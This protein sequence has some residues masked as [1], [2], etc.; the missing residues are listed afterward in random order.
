MF[1]KSFTDKMLQK[2]NSNSQGITFRGGS[3]LQVTNDKFEF[4]T[5]TNFYTEQTTE[6]IP[7]MMDYVSSPKNIPN[8]EVYDY[9]VD[10][11]LALTGE[12]ETELQGQREAINAFRASLVNQPL[13]TMLIGNTTYNLVTSAT[14]ISL[15]R[16]IVIVN[17]K[18]RVIVAMQIFVQ[19]GIDIIYGNDRVVELKLNKAGS[20]YTVLVPF[21]FGV[22]MATEPDSEMEFVKENVESIARNRT[23]TYS[24]KLF[25][26]D[27]PLIQEI[28]KDIFGI[29][30]LE[31]TYVL[32]FKL[33]DNNQAFV[34][35]VV[36]LSD[37]SINTSFG[38]QNILDL[39]FK[40]SLEDE[41]V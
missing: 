12:N 21:E 33:P 34:K 16:D 10:I 7:V 28:L 6:Y 9:T 11:T 41:I 15:V 32:R 4:K 24:M 29:V 30:E 2:L 19:S 27:V 20:N 5:Y 26:E 14:D 35:K 3:L 36:M 31:Q 13:D 39:N 8:K 38:A 22:V 25:H 1:I 40:L 17:G 37:G 18:K 23:T